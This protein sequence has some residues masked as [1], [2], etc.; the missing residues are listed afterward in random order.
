MVGH[1][2]NGAAT[3][4]RS[5]LMGSAR[6]PLLSEGIIGTNSPNML[7]E[8]PFLGGRQNLVIVDAQRKPGR[9]RHRVRHRYFT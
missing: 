2:D 7:R 9:Y 3:R 4:P 5:P 1:S 6:Y 8:R